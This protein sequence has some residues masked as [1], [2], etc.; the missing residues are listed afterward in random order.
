LKFKLHNTCN[1]TKQVYDFIQASTVY[2]EALFNTVVAIVTPGVSQIEPIASPATR[3]LV[4]YR[5]GKPRPP[6]IATE[7]ECNTTKLHR[8]GSL[9][10]FNVNLLVLIMQLVV[11]SKYISSWMTPG[12]SDRPNKFAYLNNCILHQMVQL[13]SKFA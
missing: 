12:R 13:N 5:G 3:S 1:T 7:M 6:S 4:P 9:A 2:S 11:L 8:E 10:S